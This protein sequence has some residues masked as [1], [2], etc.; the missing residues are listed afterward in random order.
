MMSPLLRPDHVGHEAETIEVVAD[1]ALC[2]ALAARLGLPAIH[3]LAATF[4]LRRE[5]AGHVR[6]SC[7]LVARV[8]QTD[9]G[10]LEPFA[11]DVGET[12]QLRFVPERLLTDAV[13][14]N[15]PVDDIGYEGQCVDLREVMA[16]Q[17]ALAL[18]PYPRAG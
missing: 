15:D 1:E 7:R 6:A 13:D 9:V 5:R 18:D 2:A 3:A 12:A 11:A 8:E 14:P 16:E 17:L 4:V 10:T